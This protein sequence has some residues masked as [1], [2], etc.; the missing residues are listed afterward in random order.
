MYATYILLYAELQYPNLCNIMS[1]NIASEA[2][3]VHGPLYIYFHI[4]LIPQIETP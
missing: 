3:R 4:T 2:K 1:Y